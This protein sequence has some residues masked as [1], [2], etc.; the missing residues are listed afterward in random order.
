MWADDLG[1]GVRS[2]DW[3]GPDW[4][5][6]NTTVTI[7][8]NLTSFGNVSIQVRRAAETL[9]YDTK[10][11]SPSEK[12]ALISSLKN[13]IQNIYISAMHLS[14]LMKLDFANKPTVQLTM[15]DIKIISS[16]YNR[17]PQHSLHSIKKNLDY[18]NDMYGHQKEIDSSLNPPN[19][20]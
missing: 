8:P 9:G 20:K 17:G 11:M 1:Y 7:D 4:T 12:N 18:G 6:K 19:K 13:P 2:I 14:D 5:D 15:D 10:I 16:R 3:S